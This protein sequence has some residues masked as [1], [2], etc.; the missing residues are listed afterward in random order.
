MRKNIVLNRFK[1]GFQLAFVIL[2]LQAG[3]IYAQQNSK[4][5]RNADIVEYTSR[6]GLPTSN[7]SS[8]AQTPDGYIWIASPQGTVR[9][10]GYEFEYVG[11]EYGL[12]EMQA[13]YY[14]SSGDNLYLAS[15][16]KL[17]RFSEG[18]YTSFDSSD[19][20]KL[21][22]P[23]GQVIS[24]I[25]KD[26]K[27]R[28]WVGS[29]S[30]FTD[31][32]FNGGLTLFENGKFTAFDSLA[33]PLHNATGFIETP[34]GDLI[35]SSSGK[36]SQNGES[37]YIALYKGNRFTIIDE[38]KGVQIVNANFRNIRFKSLFDKE[39]N[40][41]IAFNGISDFALEKEKRRTGVLMYDGDRFHQYP[42]LQQYIRPMTFI[43]NVFYHEQLGKVFAAI[44]SQSPHEFDV[45]QPELFELDNGRWIPSKILKE[46]STVR[47][48]KS[49]QKINGFRYNGI[50]FTRKSKTLPGCLILNTDGMVASSEN[51]TQYFTLDQGRWTKYEAIQG[52]PLLELKKG[53]MVKTTKGIGFYH[54]EESKMLT[55]KDGLASASVGIPNF[56]VDR[57]QLIWMSYSYSELPTYAEINPFGIN[58]WDGKR[59]RKFT[60]KDGISS[61]ITFN[62]LHD[63]RD[64]IWLGSP[65]GIT[66][67]REFKNTQGEWVFK[68]KKIPILSGRPYN[69]TTFMETRSGDIYAWQNYVRTAYGGLHKADFFLGK[70][71][72][73]KFEKIN[74]PFPAALQEKPYQLVRLREDS[75]GQLWLECSFAEDVNSLNTAKTEIRIF[76]GEE[77]YA[78][79]ES[80][81][82]PEDQLHFVGELENGTYYL[83]VGHF[84][85]FNGERFIDL[86]DSV[87]TNADFRIL[88]GASVAGT[89]T[90]IQVGDRLYIRLRNRGLVIFDGT[91][92][93][94]LTPKDGFV[95]TDIHDPMQD[96]RGNLF[97]ASRIGAV[98]ITGDNFRIYYDDENITAGGP[99]AVTIDGQGNFFKYY[100]GIGLY[101]DQQTE[102]NIDLKIA[103]VAVNSNSY[104]YEFPNK[105]KS[106]ENSLLFKYSALNYNNPAKT[107]FEHILEGYDKEWSKP[108]G[109][110][111]SEYQNLPPGKFNFRVRAKTANGFAVDEANFEFTISP[112]WWTSWWA[113]ILYITAVLTILFLLRKFELKR[114]FKNARIKESDLKAKAAEAQSRAIQAENERKTKELEEARKLQLSMLPKDVPKLPDLEIAVYMKTATEVGGD[115]Y[116]F[117]E[118][119]D[120]S[121]NIAIGDATG[122]GLKAGIMV[123]SMKSIFTT[124]ASKMDLEQFF[125]SA[126]TGIK[127]MNLQRMMM[128]F[129]MLNLNNNRLQLINAGMPPVFVFR[130]RTGSIEE[131][132]EHGVPVGAM[133]NASYLMTQKELEKGDVVLLLTDGMPE[134]R[135]EKSEMYGYERIQQGLKKVAEKAPMEIIGYYKNEASN[136]IA[137]ND[138]EDDIT[139]VVIKMK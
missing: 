60:E 31:L 70:F 82:I 135:N 30:P 133:G 9:F 119:K 96:L 72:G 98:M 109:Q 32:P 66:Q 1:I 47:N 11:K 37:A 7:I 57:N 62:I 24:F 65:N 79:P 139:F 108:S 115:Y 43:A 99:N 36:N 48:L 53:L 104:F 106:S 129:T 12:P 117:S 52:V 3:L 55:E 136:W 56:F 2:H 73:E 101:I 130:N 69:A 138:Q 121:L 45:T 111:F 8:V 22:G 33:F 71:N 41:W 114:Q 78:P 64:R 122:H 40:T 54:P 92:L 86:S 63:T 110:S 6:D 21:N 91:K 46:I 35:F 112:P 107:T 75:N 29:E 87:D 61:N 26:S 4:S 25:K 125:E 17:I 81:N 16:E 93:N 132:R 14:D 20:Y 102:I 27:D 113:Y 5:E 123:S 58:L 128:G 38:T 49:G 84:Y 59:L 50:D 124:N 13:V 97:F 131:F 76:N 42:G 68:F 89:K 18:K 120:G 10:N 39:G 94:Y 51:P 44:G 80:W 100:N 88:K 67:V 28:I 134:L 105:L 15:P 74:S 127:N 137:N 85:K 95:A 103:S 118:K 34:Y 77:W 19:G 116:D 126:N 83:T 23:S 90:D